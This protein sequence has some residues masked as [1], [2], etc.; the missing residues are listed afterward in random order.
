MAVPAATMEA[1]NEAGILNIPQLLFQR[2]D[3]LG[4][5][6]AM[7]VKEF[8]LWQDISWNTYGEKVRQA[9]MGLAALGWCP[10]TPWR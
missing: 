4:E 9:A 8:G 6:I 10:A 7:R 2:V 5:R 1:G 3:L